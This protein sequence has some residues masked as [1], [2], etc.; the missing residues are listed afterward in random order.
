[1]RAEDSAD[2]FLEAPDHDVLEGL[3]AHL[4]AAGEAVRVED[5]EERGEAA[6]VAIV[7]RRGE[8]EAVFEAL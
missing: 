1:M 6:G 8:E 4:D 7:W 2:V 3:G 5:F